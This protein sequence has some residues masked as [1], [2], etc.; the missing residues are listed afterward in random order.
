MAPGTCYR[1]WTETAHR[2]LAPF[3]RP[4]IADA[5][6]AFFALALASWARDWGTDAAALRFADPPAAGALAAGRALLRDLGALDASDAITDSG[7]AMRRLGTHP[8][9]AATM[10]AA[11]TQ[12]EAA[13]A[14][15][16]AALLEERDP[17]ARANPASADI[18]LRLDAIEHGVIPDGADRGAI[19]RIRDGARQFRRRLRVRDDV[20]PEGDPAALLAAGF[21]DRVGASRAEAGQFRLSGGGGASL[22]A[23]DPLARTALLVAPALHVGR[24]TTITLASPLDPER[25]PASLLARTTDTEERGVDE[26]TGA[27]FARRRRRLGTLVL[28]DRLLPVDGVALADALAATAATRLGERLDWTADARNWQARAALA[29]ALGIA[30]PADL[31]PIDDASLAATVAPRLADAIRRAGVTRLAD[32]GRAIDVA[33]LLR[34]ALGRDGVARLER[35]LP[36]AVALPGGRAA[37]DYTAPTPTASARAQ[38]FYG[39]DRHPAIAD[40]RVALTVALLSPAGRPIAVTGDLHAFWRNGWADA[41][42]DMRGRYPRHDWPEEPWRQP[43]RARHVPRN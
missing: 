20:A 27:V 6:L 42:R 36:D 3:D 41:R 24:G 4:E 35:A 33:A 28:S 43:S 13:R 7:R 22:A 31:P 14:A 37:I 9:L 8:R 12:G 1:L 39:L 23:S 2:A 30:D 18:A 29:L 11:A 32:L 34:A 26:R 16:L 15:N 19:A 5:E 40:G 21:P 25:L 10:L 17:L 38:A